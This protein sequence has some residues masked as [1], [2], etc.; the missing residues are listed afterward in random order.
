MNE[1][2]IEGVVPILLTP[3]DLEG[4]IDEESLERLVEFNVVSGVHGVG[5]A[6]GE[7]LVRR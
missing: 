3:F 1:L 4:R 6:L 7:A 2:R 5:V